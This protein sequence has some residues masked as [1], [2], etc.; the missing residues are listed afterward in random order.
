M[1]KFK[2]RGYLC[3]HCSREYKEKFNY[4]RHIQCCEFLNKP[5][6]EQ[7]ND[8]DS[9]EKIPSPREMLHLIQELSFRVNK[10]EKE[11]AQLRQH[12][13]K[14]INVIDWLNQNKNPTI[15]FEEWMTSIFKQVESYLEVVYNKD[16][17]TGI[18]ELLSTSIETRNEQILPIAAFNQKLNTFYIYDKENRAWDV[19]TDKDFEKT[20]NRLSH[21]FLVEFNRCWC[22]VNRDKIEKEERFKEL[23]ITYYRNILGGDKTSHET[24]INR[25]RQAF[26][27]KLQTN[28]HLLEFT[29]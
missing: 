26:Y 27:L 29:S 12:Q 11:N 1:S 16:L 4:D 18:I 21:H 17:M 19:L 28:L 25:I 22:L 3:C 6:R 13:K 8:I 10:L 14:K 24:K 5:R 20:I 7:E 15:T 9:F 23:Y 2:I